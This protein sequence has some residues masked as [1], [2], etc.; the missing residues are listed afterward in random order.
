M[1]KVKI[2]CRG[3]R[4]DRHSQKSVGGQL[5]LIYG[6]IY[7]RGSG[8]V[9]KTVVYDSGGSTPS[10]PTILQKRNLKNSKIFSIIFIEKIKRKKSKIYL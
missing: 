9:C 4:V 1:P 3:Y 10:L 6:W 2:S 5:S 7:R 8:A